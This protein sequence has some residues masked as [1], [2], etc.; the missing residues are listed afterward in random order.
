VLTG[1]LVFSVVGSYAMRNTLFDVYV[2]FAFGILGF[3]LERKKIP[4]A[5]LIL[6]LILGP[7]VE[8]NLRTGIIKSE[9]SL[10]PFFLRPVCMVL[11]ILLAFILASPTIR[12]LWNRA[13]TNE[14]GS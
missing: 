4:L 12:K 13:R 7:V 2:M 6:G 1:V 3:F 11:W 8:E 14:T 10:G 5:P 9:G